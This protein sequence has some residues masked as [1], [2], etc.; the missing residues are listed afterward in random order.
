MNAPQGA[1]NGRD[2]LDHGHEYVDCPGCPTCDSN[3]GF[4]LRKGS[5]RA[6]SSY[7]FIFMFSKTS[8]YYSDKMA[9]MEPMAPE[10]P[11]RYAYKFGGAANEHIK[12]TDNPTYLVGQR[13]ATQGRNKRDVWTLGPEPLPTPFRG[14]HF[15]AFPTMVAA[16]PI[17]ASTSPYAC[18]KCRTPWARMVGTISL[19]PWRDRVERGATGGSLERGIG[20]NHGDGMSHDLGAQSA[21]L[22]WLPTCSCSQSDGSGACTVLDIFGG[23]GTV[24]LVANRLNLN[25]I[26]IDISEKYADLAKARAEYDVAH[27][28]KRKGFWKGFDRDKW[29]IMGG[30]VE[31]EE[32]EGCEQESLLDNRDNEPDIVEQ[33]EA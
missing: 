11:A 10:S 8:D 18:P 16:I 3:G 24:S 33:E 9:V 27:P 20:E 32:N 23:T 5:W 4:I 31:N 1:R 29:Q 26:Y 14:K 2:F 6:T 22:G 12:A 28:E 19:N 17:L 13:E 25:S 7:E 21:T 15:A 30:L